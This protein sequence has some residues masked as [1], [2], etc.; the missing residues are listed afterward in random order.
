[1]ASIT[2]RNLDHTLKRRLRIRAAEQGEP[3]RTRSPGFQPAAP[4][5]SCRRRRRRAG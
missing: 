2:V 1:M 4:A 5:P 3:A